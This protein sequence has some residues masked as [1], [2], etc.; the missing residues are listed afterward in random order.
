MQL[1]KIK[2]SGFKSFVDP[3]N[4]LL[5]SN[6]VAVVGP[7]GCGKS[8]IIDAVC[9][10]MGESSAK[11]LRGES[12]T[13][14][15][16]NG[17]S[18]RKP[19]GMASVELVFDNQDGT[20]G[21]EYASYAEISIRRQISRESESAY[22]LN[23]VRCRRRDIIDIFL[24]TGLGPRSYSIIGQNMIS[25]IIEAK[26]DD[27]RVYLEEAA[28]VSR[29]KERRR[30]T[31]N[32][33]QHTKDNLARLNDVRTELDKQLSTLKRQAN[34]AEKF[35]VLK[36]EERIVRAQWLTI[37]WRD[38]DTLLVNE[39]LQIQQQ[40]TGLEARQ[41]ELCE[42]NLQLDYQRENERAA[43]ETVQE[44]QR[45][46]YV[47]G[48]E[49]TRLEQEIH[50]YQ[51]RQK[52]WTL[53]IEQN[54]KDLTEVKQTLDEAE[55]EYQTLT[56]ESQ[57]LEPEY[58]ST[59]ESV[60]SMAAQLTQ[61]EQDMH[62]WQSQWDE[63]N[64][65]TAK[66]TQTAQVEQTRIQHL[67]QKIASIKQRQVKLDQEKSQLDFFKLEKEIEQISEE[68]SLAKEKTEESSEQ[69][70]EISQQI[71]SLRTTQ[72]KTTEELNKVR[73]ELQILHGRQASL[74]ALQETALGRKNNQLTKWLAEH[75]L[76]KQPRLAERVEV[77]AGWEY[78]V[79]KVLGAYLQAVCVEDMATISSLVTQFK[80][81]SL[82]VVSQHPIAQSM[83][84]LENTLFSK[85][86]SAW[87]LA[88][89][90]TGIYVAE[91]QEEAFAKASSLATDESIIT[92]EGVWLGATWL[93]VSRDDNPEAGVFQ[94][95]Q[96]LKQLAKKIAALKSQQETLEQAVV[97]QREQLK[98]LEKQRD[99]LQKTA[100]QYHAQSAEIHAKQAMSQ[101]RLLD[102]KKRV[103]QYTKEQTE[104][105]VQLEQSQTDLTKSRVVWQQAMN[106]LEQQ[107]EKREA[108]IHSR[109]SLR[110]TL[111]SA[112][113]QLNQVKEEAHQLE[114]RLQT[115][116]SQQA[117]LKQSIAR[118]QAQYAALSGRKT[119]LENDRHA[120]LSPDSLQQ[121]L[122]NALAS[123]LTIEG[124]LHA[125]RDGMETV[126][127][128]LHALEIRRQEIERDITGYR[129]MLET[130]RIES[131]GMRVKAEMLIEQ[132]RETGFQIEDVLKELPEIA[133][134][135]DWHARL[136]QI[137]GRISRLGAINLVAIEEYST[138]AERKAYLDKQNDDLQEGLATLENA[139]AKIDKE[140]R[141]RFKETFDKVNSRFCEL[142][143]TVFGGGHANLE[144]TGDNL[145]DAG[146]TVMAC[147]PGKR[148][149]TI[150]LLSGGEKALT[151]IALV[152]S[153][154][155]LNPA[156]F[157]LL[158]EVD[159]PLDD[160]NIGRFCNLVKA[161]S[162]KTQFIFI[163][164]NKLAIEMG[165]NLIG[166][167]MHE[168]G[169][170]R[171]VTVDIQEAISL[172]GA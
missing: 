82:C 2:L 5:P 109:D 42:L 7:N 169:V 45:R 110:D 93:R 112:R 150:H 145:L 117:S 80:E 151:A 146:I 30:E 120:A 69:L 76:D 36:Q 39:T 166:V 114:I 48:S 152:F 144:L 116:K 66:N 64:Q 100:N 130:L 107:A 134:A 113:N 171:L 103:E 111:Q 87:P 44:V 31:E 96:E 159:A 55:E 1:K 14:V 86:N 115:T 62:D 127:Q 27:M 136:E 105:V 170:S 19:V 40:S 128:A 26:P 108:L 56:Q 74:D 24:G 125:T 83:K 12:L 78:A 32:R 8:N 85:I 67:E 61:A 92:R 89:L 140:T 21:G 129:D 124:D 20:L 59:S 160:A 51:E 3:T 135:D 91:S 38:Q 123:R 35:Q 141:A 46:Y 99:L 121:D 102:L 98:E 95:D 163:S 143:P 73:N 161:M 11:Y 18:A 164:H 162:E 68:A 118:M 132:I 22:F 149:S 65:Q 148:N 84:T 122:A 13:D 29:Y 90:F 49:I 104:S 153:I 72:Q 168:P 77:E 52:Q 158:D 142:F 138:C 71:A 17:S 50:H 47:I 94:R 131:Q 133:A 75:K 28:G 4:V 60:L 172:A 137:T 147:P 33:I 156:P 126:T 79:E 23:G 167:T 10:V 16:F 81:G 63:F 97:D 58:Q 139:I 41:A 43:Q 106:E 6:L 157:C 101:E 15:I 119:G 70:S 25:R 88:S 154:F 34:S 9:W 165:E 57:E 37:Q 155:H 54:N 53:D